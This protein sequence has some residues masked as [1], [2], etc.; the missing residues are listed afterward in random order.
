MADHIIR[1]PL[2]ETCGNCRFGQP[3]RDGIGGAVQLGVVECHGTPPTPCIA[4]M[5]ANGPAVV[6]M[7]P[8]LESKE[9]ACGLWKL[10]PDPAQAM[11]S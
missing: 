2:I 11:D 10:R 6:L 9:P 1:P 7:R 4:G 8:R 5:S 3:V